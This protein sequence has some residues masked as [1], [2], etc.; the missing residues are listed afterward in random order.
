MTKAC[1]E[2]NRDARL[3][4]GIWK[5]PVCCF[6]WYL[7]M[8]AGVGCVLI[9][10]YSSKKDVTDRLLVWNSWLVRSHSKA[11]ACF[12]TAVHR[13]KA[14]PLGLSGNSPT[15]GSCPG[16]ACFS[17]T[18]VLHVVIRLDGHMPTHL[19]SLSSITELWSNWFNLHL[20]VSAILS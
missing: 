17:P 2:G 12:H 4:A 13:W 6:C 8:E 19:S 1:T 10:Q 18:H 11:G 20:F 7:C 16:W 15:K 9:R 5:R 14:I 3:T